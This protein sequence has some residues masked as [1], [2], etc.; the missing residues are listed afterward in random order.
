MRLSGLSASP[1]T[2]GS[3]VRFPVRAHAWVAG[4]VPFVHERQTHINVSLPLSFPTPLSKIKKKKKKNSL[5]KLDLWRGV[6]GPAKSLTS[7]SEKPRMAQP[8]KKDH[9]GEADGEV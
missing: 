6:G 5:L 1:Q 3:L 4:Q 9:K 2:K 7:Q 8:P